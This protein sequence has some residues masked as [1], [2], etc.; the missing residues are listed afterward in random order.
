MN[1]NQC[2]KERLWLIVTFIYFSKGVFSLRS[3]LEEQAALAMAL[4]R[5]QGPR[6]KVQEEP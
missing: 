6:P 3:H 2:S 5:L 1:Y 4:G